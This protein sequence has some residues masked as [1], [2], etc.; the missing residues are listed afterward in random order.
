M[1]CS[2]LILFYSYTFHVKRNLNKKNNENQE[3]LKTFHDGIFILPI[4]A[5]TLFSAL[6]KFSV[7]AK[8]TEAHESGNNGSGRNQWTVMKSDN[9]FYFFR[10]TDK[11]HFST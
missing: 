10:I 9:H 11:I 6:S 3:M 7:S 5:A 2:Y 4:P 8:T 1:L